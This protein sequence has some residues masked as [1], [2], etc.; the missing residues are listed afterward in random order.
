MDRDLVCVA[1]RENLRVVCFNAGLK[2]PR[3]AGK[4]Q[5]VFTNDNF[6]RIFAITISSN[7]GKSGQI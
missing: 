4:V 6:G 1:D 3:D 5:K 2:N 7:L